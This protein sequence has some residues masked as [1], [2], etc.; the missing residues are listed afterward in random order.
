MSTIGIIGSG[1]IGA[2]FAR[3]AVL[4]G[5]D[6]VLANSRSPETLWPLAAALGP[7][8]RAATAEQ[9]ADAGE[10][11]LVSVP[12]GRY[13]QLPVAPLA[14][15]VVLDT[16]NYYP[17]RD[18]HFAELDLRRATTSE[19]V[20]AHLSGA[21][22]VKVMNNIWFR[23]LG[24]LSRP[25]GAGD[26]STLPVAGDHDDAK[27]A[28][29]ELVD[30]L[31]YDTYDAGPLSESWRFERDQPAYVTPYGPHD[32]TSAPTPADAGTLAAALAEAV[33]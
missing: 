26:R 7:R 31:G 20:Q 3:L 1:N 13:L 24:L 18:G 32:A 21:F 27:T 23:H 6:V 29:R 8:A 5:H 11:V 9:A 22:V 28:A 10:L 16:N 30:Q 25:G 4:A 19:L 14:G 33:R 15:K 12:F 2:T 17:D